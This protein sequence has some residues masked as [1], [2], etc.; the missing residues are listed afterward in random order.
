MKKI[1]FI[2]ALTL[3]ASLPLSYAY[4]S[5]G[6][7]SQATANKVQRANNLQL[8]N[9]LDQAVTMLAEMRPS[10]AYDKAYVQ[11]MLGVFYWQQGKQSQAISLLTKAVNSGLLHDDQAWTTERMLADILLSEAKYSQ[12]LPHYYKLTKNIPAK[13]K[14]DELWLLIAQAHYQQA[15]WQQVLTAMKRY[16]SYR[17]KDSMSPLSIQLGAQLQLKHWS[18]ATSTL[19]RLI[20]LE[21]NKLIWWQQLASIQLQAGKNADALSTLKLA[22]YQG[23][24]LTQRDLHTLAQLYA[25]RG[26]PER[27]A[28]QIAA[29]DGAKNDKKLLI[30]QANYWQMAR[31]WNKAIAL[32]A[33]VANKDNHYRWQLSQLLLQEGHYQR[34]LTELNRVKRKDKRADVELAKV[35]VYYKLNQFDQAIIHAKQ[36]NNIQASSAAKSWIKYLGQMRKMDV[37]V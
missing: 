9:K 4:A 33:V 15:Q 26:I 34:A 7:L 21:P 1:A 3:S 28:E 19:N 36:A 11:R 37:S 8:D 24:A 13:Q 27:A 29:L 16:D 20:A 25:Q 10:S 2:V 31:E 18:G 12:A 17:L 14:G 30:E 6:Q 35:R 23:V 5:G 22:K 32:W